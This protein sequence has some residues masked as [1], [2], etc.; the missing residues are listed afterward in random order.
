MDAPMTMTAAATLNGKKTRGSSSGVLGYVCVIVKRGD[1]RKNAPPNP[2]SLPTSARRNPRAPMARA[3]HV[4]RT[5]CTADA[6]PG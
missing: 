3:A 4:A 6:A 1:E 2:D 5:L